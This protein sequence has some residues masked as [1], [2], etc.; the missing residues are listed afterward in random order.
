MKT[1][2]TELGDSRVRVDVGIDADSVEQ[3]LERA[4]G[5]LA[6]D[7]RMPGFRKGKVPPQ[8]VIQRVGRDAVL[9]QALRDSLPEWYERALLDTG[10]S[11]VGDPQLDVPSLPDAGED[12]S[13][14]IEVA[15]RPKARLGED[16]GLEVGRGEAAVPD[17]AVKTEP[18]RLRVGFASLDPADP[19]AA[20]GDLVGIDFPGTV[21]W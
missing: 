10:I 8:L 20:G 17:D 5:E 6:R 21:E 15:V 16:T 2:V 13:F 7:M 1:S 11:P 18:D 19:A 9:E 14:S 4:A 12:L 3:R